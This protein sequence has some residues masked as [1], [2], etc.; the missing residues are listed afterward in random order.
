[1]YNGKSKE[2]YEGQAEKL[3]RKFSEPRIRITIRDVADVLGY[4]SHT[5][6]LN[7]IQHMIEL[8]EVEKDGHAYYLVEK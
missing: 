8:G 4:K 2:F 6:A 3:R 5:G 7:V 1:M